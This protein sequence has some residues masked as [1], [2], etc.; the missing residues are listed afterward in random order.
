LKE[1]QESNEELQKLKEKTQEKKGSD[2]HLD[3][4]GLLYFKGRC[5]ISN[6]EDIKQEILAEAHQ[7]KFSMHPGEIKIYQDILRACTLDIGNRWVDNVAYAEFAYY[8]IFQ[9]TIGMALFEA[10][11]GRKCQSPLY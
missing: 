8:N 5:C 11:Y 1:A 7:S 2:F 3:N 9:S 10:L 6:Q 4:E